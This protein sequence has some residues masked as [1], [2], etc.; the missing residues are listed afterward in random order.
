MKQRGK[1]IGL[2]NSTVALRLTRSF[3]SLIV[4]ISNVPKY[5]RVSF[6]GFI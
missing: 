2:K 1:I 6:A 4:A 5:L 3:S